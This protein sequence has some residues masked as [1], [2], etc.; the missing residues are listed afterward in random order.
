MKLS[1]LMPVYNESATIDLAVKQVLSV[2]YPC[3]ME[4]VIVDDG[5]VDDT[6]ARLESMSDER[7]TLHRHT[8]NQGKGA[9]I[10]TA[11]RAA[12]GDYLIICDA[13]LEYMPEEIPS[14]LAPVLA[15]EAEVV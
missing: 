6:F 4:L 5:S 7:L 12:S 14:L 3:E 1:V 11:S 8:K 9:A 13:D 2:D 15:Q 10:R